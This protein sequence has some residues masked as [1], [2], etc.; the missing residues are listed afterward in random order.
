MVSSRPSVALDRSL[1][2]GLARF[3]L[4]IRAGAAAWDELTRVARRLDADRFVVVRDH[5]V[6]AA[7]THRVLHH[8]GAAAP[9]RLVRASGT[10]AVGG[11]DVSADAVVVGLDG[12]S[13]LDAVGRWAAHTRRGP[14]LLPTTL[15]AVLDTAL[16][17]GYLPAPDVRLDPAQTR[18]SHTMATLWTQFAT[19]ASPD[20]VTWPA[21]APA[22][23]RTL[24][25]APDAITGR[26]DFDASHQCAFWATV[27]RPTSQGPVAQARRDQLTVSP[28]ATAYTS[29]P[30]AAS[31]SAI[32]AWDPP[33]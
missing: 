13:V 14:L 32:S 33:T 17:L 28:A 30:G 12:T 21:T 31:S 22:P 19:T 2:S 25:L 29:S 9:T 27:P 8:L 26:T 24:S 10:R 7:H 23:Y 5:G 4:Q 18:L 16:S 11:D 20:P 6:P 1:G 3:P 15:P